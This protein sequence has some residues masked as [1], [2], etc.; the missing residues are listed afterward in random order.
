MLSDPINQVFTD[1]NALG[2]GAAYIGPWYDLYN[3]NG[4]SVLLAGSEVVDEGRLEWSNN[5]NTVRYVST[6]I[7][8][9]APTSFTGGA[10]SFLVSPLSRYVRVV[11][12]NG[13]VQQPDADYLVQLILLVTTPDAPQ[14]GGG[15]GG[16]GLTNTELR[17]SP[18][19]VSI[20]G[21]VT[22]AEPV[23]IDGTVAVSGSVAVTGPLTDTQLRAAP[24]P[25]TGTVST[26]GLT[27][28]ELRAT[29]VDV[30]VVGTVTV[31]EPVTVDGTIAL[32][33]PTLAALE[34][35]SAIITSL[36]AVALD[37]ATL[38]ALETINAVVSGTVELGATTLAALETIQANCTQVG[39]W[40]VDLSV[41]TLAALETINAVQSGAW[42]VAVNNFP[43][44]QPV[45]DNGGSL[46]VDGT[47]AVSSVGGT[48]AVTG[49]LT[50][51]QLR[52]TPVPVSGTV[53]TGG[54]TDTQL[55]AT[56]VP[57]S[58]TVTATGPLTD[59]QL[60]AVAVPVSGTVTAN[61][62]TGPWPVTDNGGSL[63][64][65][66]TVA[67]SS[68]GGTVA[69]S[70]PLTDTQLRAVPVPVS[71]TVT[72]NQPVNTKELNQLIPAQYDFI[73]LGYTGDDITTVVYK[74]GGSGGTTV[75]TLTLVYSSPGVLDTVTRT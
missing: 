66:G 15:G 46:T 29:P 49:P 26:T 43:A 42:T 37:A 12:E 24:V 5:A 45:S 34:N 30:S 4:V 53:T 59:A 57:V 75:A 13:S 32:D 8:G 65:D 9:V 39:T 7:A 72:V 14:T 16:G 10:A 55:R 50:D 62:G 68:V 38:A 64:V 18:V 20:S 19:P 31:S 36:P 71:G 21:S 40:T 28:A 25:V 35:I 1:E 11:V 63:T 60:R 56:P 6:F 54:L 22:V 70:G 51:T 67:V 3:F 27:D 61:A 33:A 74:T 52:A 17:A 48:V 44:V 41:A 58:G 23:T 2:P 73:D 47:V 69:V